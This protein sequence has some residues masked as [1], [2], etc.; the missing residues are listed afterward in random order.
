MFSILSRAETI[1]IGLSASDSKNYT[2]K[3]NTMATIRLPN[4]TC[5]FKNLTLSSTNGF[6][7]FLILFHY[8]RRITSDDDVVGK[9][10]ADNTTSANYYILS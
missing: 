4:Y 1:P 2:L 3:C 9:A 8:P 10:A 5:G 7:S 6:T